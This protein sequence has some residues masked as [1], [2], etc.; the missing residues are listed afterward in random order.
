MAPIAVF[1]VSG[2]IDDFTRADN[3]YRTMKRE[4][5]K[6]LKK[7]KIEFKIDYTEIEGEK[8]GV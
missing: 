3:L 8:T 7:W 2:E 5:E 6:L 4:T 1:T